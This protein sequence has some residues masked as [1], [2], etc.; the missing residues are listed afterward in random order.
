M[1]TAR[2]GKTFAL[3]L[4]CSLGATTEAGA[5]QC[6]SPF[7][8]VVSPPDDA[9][10]VPLNARIVVGIS[11]SVSDIQCPETLQLLDES[12]AAVPTE[13]HAFWTR[14]GGVCVLTPSDSL[15]PN[16]VYLISHSEPYGHALEDG[17]ASFTT[18][19]SADFVPPE[20]PSEVT[21]RVTNYGVPSLSMAGPGPPHKTAKITFKPDVDTFV[22]L[23]PS[24]GTMSL[25]DVDE[26]IAA[27]T[28]EEFRLTTFICEW[29]LRLGVVGSK[30]EFSLISV[31]MAGNFSVPLEIT[32]VT[33]PP[34][35]TCQCVATAPS[36]GFGGFF[37][38]ALLAIGARRRSIRRA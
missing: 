34:F 16:A 15:T 19:D 4:L 36:L 14:V 25:E 32:L 13:G 31:D 6:V 21:V 23:L 28:T 18:G 17:R 1:K 22:L 29:T 38:L 20:P 33:P 8:P 35:L 3:I 12:G 30:E 26:G 7:A 9:V 10:G 24:P 37:A 5:W 11:S 2:R 27:T